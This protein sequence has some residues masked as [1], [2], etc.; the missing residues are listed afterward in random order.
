LI[1]QSI[2][3]CELFLNNCMPT[4]T[5]SNNN[6]SCC[7]YGK[8]LDLTINTWHLFQNNSTPINIT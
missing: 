2:P 5:C 1:W 7:R 3:L 4:Q 8:T 6:R